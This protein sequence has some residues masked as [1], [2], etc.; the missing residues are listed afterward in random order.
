M[1]RMGPHQR[2]VRPCG[3]EFGTQYSF[4]LVPEL[5][6][7]LQGTQKDQSMITTGSLVTCD[8]DGLPSN[9]KLII[10][11]RTTGRL[12]MVRGVF[13]DKCD[14]LPLLSATAQC[15]MH[16]PLTAVTLH[17]V[18]YKAL[19][20]VEKMVSKTNKGAHRCAK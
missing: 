7:N 11:K 13:G 9:D 10:K 16:V 8:L 4:G 3:H 20:F 2:Q 6:R 5:Q 14:L 19:G 15:A 12:W 17:M 1:R 18:N